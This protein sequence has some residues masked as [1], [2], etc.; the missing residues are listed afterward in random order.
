MPATTPAWTTP[1]DVTTRLR[2]RW[3]SGIYL[4]DLAEETDWEPVCI[5]L[6]GPKP[7]E[8]TRHYEA[9]REWAQSWATTAARSPLRL[10]HRRVGGQLVGRNDIPHQVWVDHREDL[11]KLLGVTNTVHRYQALLASAR[12]TVPQLAAWM[13]AHPMKVVKLHDVW[14]RLE[15]TVR[16]IADYRGP[17]LYVRQIDVPGVDTKFIEHHRATLT[18]LL[19]HC[20]PADRITD[21]AP[22]TNFAARFGFLQKPAYLRFRILGGQTLAGFRE[23]TV[24][25]EEFTARPP[26]VTTVYVVENETTYLAFPSQPDSIVILGG[27]YA[28]TQLSHLPWLHDVRL[29]YWGDLDTHGFAILNRLRRA[30]PHTES[31]LMNR[32]VLMTHKDQWVKEAGPTV[33]SLEALTHEESDVYRILTGGDFGQGVRLEQERVRFCLL[34]EA[35]ADLRDNSQPVSRLAGD[36]LLPKQ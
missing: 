36:R 15:A 1:H 23:L 7:G 16:W 35:L 24:R 29:I 28:V 33:E 8:I 6:R 13:A 14:P 19:E 3:E 2:K 12:A 32:S 31:I 27:G 26:G 18:A 10:E 11:W 34:Q 20:L 25:T 9:V 30:F 21:A 17:A 5:P 4:T 22:R